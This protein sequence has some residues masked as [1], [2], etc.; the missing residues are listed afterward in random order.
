MKKKVVLFYPR[1]PAPE[2][3]PPLALLAISAPL[4]KEGYEVKIVDANVD[5][6]FQQLILKEVGDA[7]FLGISLVTGPMVLDT[8]SVG[9]KVKEIYPRIP[10]VLG[11]WHPSLFPETINEDFVDIVVKGQ[12]EATVMELVKALETGSSIEHIKGISFKKDGK[13]I[14]NPRREYIDV[15]QLPPKPYEITDPERYFAKSGTRWVL[16]YTSCGCPYNCTYCCNHAVYG[17]KWNG[18]KPDRVVE[19]VSDLV[20]RF[21]IGC[22]GF[23]D[24]NFFASEKRI[25]DLTN[26]FIKNGTHFKWF[27]QGRGDRIARFKEETLKLMVESGCYQIFFGAESGSEKV[28][29]LMNKKEKNEDILI[30]A[31]RCKEWGITSTFFFIFGYP[32]ETEEDISAS[33]D[34]IEQIR[35]R[36]PQAVICTSIFTPYPG[37]PVWEH[38]VKHGIET[39]KTFDGWAKFNP[40]FMVLPWL[41]PAEMERLTRIKRYIE[42]GFSTS[43]NKALKKEKETLNIKNLFVL[44]AQQR[45]KRRFYNFPFELWIRK[46][47]YPYK[48]ASQEIGK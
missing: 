23:N 8:M 36:N 20:K 41:N 13:V 25:A 4:V 33:L 45:I 38:A 19:E 22:I 40:R 11:G 18:L 12:G 42:I 10:I 6:N 32:G 39:P 2:V 47:F 17:G 3:A 1:Y 5:D 43:L 24:D 44:L 26:G 15:N 28:L 46:F 35:V 29:A 27:A 7:I 37:S 48:P 14:H 30:S 16:Y 31:E 21:R 34:L 9:R